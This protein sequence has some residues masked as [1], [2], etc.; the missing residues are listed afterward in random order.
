MSDADKVL[1]I[2]GIVVAAVLGVIALGLLGGVSMT[3]VRGP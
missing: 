1:W 3:T 2:V